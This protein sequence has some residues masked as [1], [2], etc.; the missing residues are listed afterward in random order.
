M[1]GALLVALL[2]AGPAAGQ[3]QVELTRLQVQ[4]GPVALS[5][6]SPSGGGDIAITYRYAPAATTEPTAITV[7]AAAEDP[8]L[9]V[10][11]SPD[12]VHAAVQPGGGETTVHTTLFATA[13]QSYLPD[14]TARVSIT[15]VAQQNGNLPGAGNTTYAYVSMSGFELPPRWMPMEDRPQPAAQPPARSPDAAVALVALA[16]VAGALLARRR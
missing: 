1:R 4:A 14:G 8:R 11:V 10:T 3:A 2:L 6:P 15:A 7:T 9:R 16:L 5:G 13:N 12:T